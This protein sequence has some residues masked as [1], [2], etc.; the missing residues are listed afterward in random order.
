MRLSNV[1]IRGIVNPITGRINSSA[2]S[3]VL[4]VDDGNRFIILLGVGRQIRTTEGTQL[5]V[6][7]S[8]PSFW[9]PTRH[10]YEAHIAISY[11]IL[12][13]DF[14]IVKHR[15]A[16]DGTRFNSINELNRLLSQQFLNM[17]FGR[18]DVL[19]IVSK[20]CECMSLTTDELIFFTRNSP[21]GGT[22]YDLCVNGENS[23]NAKRY[24]GKGID[25]ITPCLIPMKHNFLN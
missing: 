8:S 11:N 23:T 25:S 6:G 24:I 14:L 22:E 12:L 1:E 9:A 20:I 21:F 16:A 18:Y 10:L 4:H 17:G 7:Y 5:E 13:R 15:F 3:L 2:K 19:Y